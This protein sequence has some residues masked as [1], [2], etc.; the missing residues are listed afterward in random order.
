MS[1]ASK[2]T[3]LRHVLKCW[4][5]RGL[6][7]SQVPVGR[8]RWGLAYRRCVARSRPS[9]SWLLPHWQ[10]HN[11]AST[12][13]SAHAGGA[14][15]VE[16]SAASKAVGLPKDTTAGITSSS[17]DDSA[18]DARKLPGLHKIEAAKVLP[19]HNVASKFRGVTFFRLLGKW[20]A[21][22]SW[23]GKRVP[24]GFFADQQQAAEAYDKAA[25]Y[26]ALYKD[27]PSAN[28]KLNFPSDTYAEAMKKLTGL[29]WTEV[30]R[31][32]RG[33]SNVPNFRGVT[34]LHYTGKWKA[35]INRQG[36]VHSLGHFDNQEQAAATFDKAALYME[37]KG[38][39][40]AKLNFPSDDYEEDMEE[41]AGLD[42]D[43][44][45]QLL[46]GRSKSSKF[47]GVY[48]D[49][50]RGKW[51]ARIRRQGVECSLGLFAD[52][53]QAAATYDKAALYIELKGGP[54]AKPNFPSDGYEEDL[55]ELAGG[56]GCILSCLHARKWQNEVA[57][58]AL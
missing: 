9:Q 14:H 24:L 18:N 54:A 37:F 20:R 46:R 50:D 10:R 15:N 6:P 49:Q 34:L 58:S 23:E 7:G 55:E 28:V 25:L 33:R 43:E 31:S 35:Q 53:E 38:G 48:L 17:S 13:L 16:A 42:W 8:P 29:E 44:V 4:N 12:V 19:R 1:P 32:I 47:R 2:A 36:V 41:L 40:A 11:G 21:Q 51:I 30:V 26:K 52:Q 27:D 57:Q 39:P 22:I 3:P 45:V 56:N 5:T